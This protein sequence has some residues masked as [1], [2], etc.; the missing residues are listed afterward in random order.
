MRNQLK[1]RSPVVVVLG[2][3]DAGKTTLLDYIRKTKVAQ[4]EPG[5]ITQSIGAYEIEIK[6]ERITFI[7]TPGHQAF[8]RMRQRGA[9]VAD[10]AILVVAADEGVKDQTIEV[11]KLLQQIKLPYIVAI[12]KID[13]SQA[14]VEKTKSQLLKHGVMLEKYGGDVSW[15]EISA[16]TGKGI[17]ELLDLIILASQMLDLKYNPDALPS[18]VIIEVEKTS[19]RGIEATAILKD[20]VLKPNLYIKTPTASGKIKL[21]ENFLRKKVDLLVPSAP[22]L[23]LGFK[24]PPQVGERFTTSIE[25]PSEKMET[26]KEIV[27]STKPAKFNLILKAKDFGS[28]E[29]LEQ[30]IR[31]SFP[32][33]KILKKGIGN[34]SEEDVELASQFKAVII[35]FKTKIER[36][37]QQLQIQKK[38]DIITSEII[39]KLI[40]SLEKHLK[41]EP[42]V[43]AEFDVLKVFRVEKNK[44][45]IGGKVNSGELKVGQECEILREGKTIG[46]GKV[47]NLQSERKDVLVVKQ[48]ELAGVKIEANV[49][50]IPKDR[51]IFKRLE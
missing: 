44:Q 1:A 13:K 23:I 40:E 43:V 45:I 20:G 6:G 14:N 5:E 17:E 29:A 27:I 38:V 28:L 4:T 46:Q 34:I 8:S 21:L 39:Y 24:Y 15:Q 22:T 25:P 2:H 11:I 31:A 12:N 30:I 49:T 35:G 37:A 19:R 50:I 36:I 33:A 26:K 3:I 41:P 47:L 18:G 7:D 10:L 9:Q 16:K 48:G 42:K 32:D 51:L